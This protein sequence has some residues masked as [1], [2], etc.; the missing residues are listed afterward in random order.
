[1]TPETRL[2]HRSP[3]PLV[4]VL[5][6]CLAV[7]LTP[8]AFAQTWPN[9]PISLVVGVPPGSAPDA[10][11]RTVAERLSREIGQQVLVETRAGANGNV[12]AEYVLRAPADGHTL[13]VA[14]Q[15]M[16]EINPTAYDQLR[17][18]PTDF[19]GVIKGAEA[20][21]VL[22]V[23]PSVPAR[24]LA[25]FITW[26]RANPTRASYGS[27]GG[28]TTSQFAGY[29]LSE[30][31]GI[32]MTHVPFN[33]SAPQVQNLIGGHILFGFT[34]IQ[35]S[36]AQV[37]DGRLI[38]IATSGATRWRQLGAV[39]T[40]VE[41]GYRDLVATTWFGL[42][43]RSSTPPELLARVTE[44]TVRAHADPDLRTKLEAMGLDVSGLAGAA[45]DEDLRTGLARWGAIVKA[46]GFRANQ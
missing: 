28:G 39:P 11:A 36:L 31:L 35:T 18:K 19:T 7:L 33:G 37:R 23:H 4:G 46:T 20:P 34:Q 41:L 40:L 42:L 26:A 16:A 10:Y 43:A 32:A 1:M 21:L 17:W 15:S 45:F 29:L 9:R 3:A 22:A 38:A 2:R 14:A 44:A 24:N 13:W 5:L 30:R 12:A 27:F 8:T 25:E 6:A